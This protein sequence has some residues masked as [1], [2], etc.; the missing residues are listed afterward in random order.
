MSTVLK[1][2]D[3]QVRIFIADVRALGSMNSQRRWR[4]GSSVVN[5]VFLF[6]FK[7]IFLEFVSV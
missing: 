5:E 2:L 1:V 4:L 7:W 6:L 3:R